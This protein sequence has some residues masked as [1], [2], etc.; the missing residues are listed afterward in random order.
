[1]ITKFDKYNESVE[2]KTPNETL[3]GFIS[4]NKGCVTYIHVTDSEEAAKGIIE[5]GFEYD[6]FG[7]TTDFVPESDMVTLNYVR[8]LRKAYGNYIMVIQIDE[9][10]MKR[11]KNNA[12]LLSDTGDDDTL[13]LPKEYVKGYFIQDV[14]KFVSNPKFNPKYEK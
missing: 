14:M 13:I 1:M 7:K 2:G 3:M 4:T 6:I 10:V 12:E 11:N 5:T 8:I 9:D